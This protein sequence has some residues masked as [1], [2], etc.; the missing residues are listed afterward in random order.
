MVS[1]PLSTLLGNPV[2]RVH[3]KPR[4]RR[5]LNP[6]AKGPLRLVPVCLSGACGQVIAPMAR[7]VCRDGLAALCICYSRAA[8]VSESIDLIIS[9]RRYFDP[10]RVSSSLGERFRTTHDE[11]TPL[12]LLPW[13]AVEQT[14]SKVAFAIL[15]RDVR[16]RAR[17]ACGHV[18][19]FGAHCKKTKFRAV[20]T[21]GFF[22]LTRVF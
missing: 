8:L 12:A 19:L 2:H 11:R 17:S 1:Y 16:I 5:S 3:G 21:I 13:A 9:S 7:A 6:V 14:P 22:L 10:R 20:S 15:Q 18:D 4:R